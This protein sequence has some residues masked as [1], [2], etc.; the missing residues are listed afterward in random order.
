[1][2]T[3][4]P[5]I[6]VAVRQDDEHEA[7]DVEFTGRWIL[8]PSRDE[9]RGGDP[10]DRSQDPGVYWGL[11]RTVDSWAVYSNHVTRDWGRLQLYGELYSALAVLPAHLAEK[12]RDE[13]GSTCLRCGRPA[14]DDLPVDWEAD[15]DTEGTAV[16]CPDCITPEEEQATLQEYWTFSNEIHDQDSPDDLPTLDD[17]EQV[18]AALA[19]RLADLRQ[20]VRT[21]DRRAALIELRELAISHATATAAQGLGNHL[22]DVLTPVDPTAALLELQTAQHAAETA[23]AAALALDPTTETGLAAHT[24]ALA[25]HDRALTAVEGAVAA[26]HARR[27]GAVVDELGDLATAIQRVI[28]LEPDHGD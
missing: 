26:L 24:A 22:P 12:A 4:Q 8:E 2:D 1:M 20:Q 5:I 27:R 17:D 25:A 15:G 21:G 10:A 13:L 6:T 16:I 7:V 23:D 14:P 28:D 19:E 3:Q 18:L 11:A 9:T